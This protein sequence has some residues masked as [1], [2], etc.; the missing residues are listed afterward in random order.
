MVNA[1]N[2]RNIATRQHFMADLAEKDEKR[3]SQIRIH[4]AQ[5]LN[6]LNKYENVTE[7]MLN[8][9]STVWVEHGSGV[10]TRDDL[11]IS[12]GK[13]DAMLLTLASYAG[14]V[15]N[16]K[17]PSYGAKLPFHPY[18]R[19]Q[20]WRM[21]IVEAPS[22]AIRVPPTQ[23]F[24]MQQLIEKKSVTIKQARFVQKALLA[25]K[26]IVISGVTGSGKTTFASGI[27]EYLTDGRVFLVEDNPEI[28]IPAEN[29]LSILTNEFFSSRDAVF[30]SLRGRPDKL[31]LGEIRDGATAVET[32]NAW[33]T[34]H[35]GIATI[36]ASSAAA[37]KPRLKNLCEQQVLKA[38]QE[39]IDEV[40]NVVVHVGKVPG[41][42]KNKGTMRRKVLE[43][44]DFTEDKGGVYV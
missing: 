16:H 20:G 17:N 43:I 12:P 1:K 28:V 40:V 7:I 9:D 19:F 11:V 8:P 25:G 35:G 15:L 3:I 36:H 44:L 41:T 34:G 33:L 22:F 24:T 37:V 26:N 39:L 38:D 32:L 14:E 30:T 2:N 29:K 21:P 23:R 42:G 10:M 5:I 4:F 27:L 13:A 18:G 31:I 6:L